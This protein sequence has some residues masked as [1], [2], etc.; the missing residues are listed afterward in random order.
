MDELL[1]D[2]F[3][4]AQIFR[5]HQDVYGITPPPKTHLRPQYQ[6]AASHVAGT[7]PVYKIDSKDTELQNKSAIRIDESSMEKT[8]TG[9]ITDRLIVN[10]IVQNIDKAKSAIIKQ[11]GVTSAE[12]LNKFVLHVIEFA[13]TYDGVGNAKPRAGITGENGLSSQQLW[14]GFCAQQ[15]LEAS[16]LDGLYSFKNATEFSRQYQIAAK[17]SGIY[18]GREENLREDKDITQIGARLKRIPKDMNDEIQLEL[19]QLLSL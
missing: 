17:A 5:N 9:A 8:W 2:R 18:T 11:V 19:Q 10:K 6:R 13:Q 15:G 1:E 12:K 3:G 14:E 7:L 4:L 16:D